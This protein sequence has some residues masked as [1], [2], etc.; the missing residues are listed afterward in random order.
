MHRKGSTSSSHHES[1]S[2]SEAPAA[3][4]GGQSSTPEANKKKTSISTPEEP[5]NKLAARPKRCSPKGCGSK[6]C[7]AKGLTSAGPKKGTH[8]PEK[9]PAGI[10]RSLVSRAHDLFTRSTPSDDEV[11]HQLS[12]RAVIK[13]ASAQIQDIDAFVGRYGGPDYD[14]T[15]RRITNIIYWND[16]RKS[17]ESTSMFMKLGKSAFG[18]SSSQLTGCTVVVVISDKAVWFAHFWESEDF[19]DE[20]V[21]PPVT[22]RRRLPE[23][24]TVPQANQLTWVPHQR[25]LRMLQAR[26]NVKN[27]EFRSVKQGEGLQGKL[28]NFRGRPGTKVFM[29]TPESVWHGQQGQAENPQQV[30]RLAQTLHEMVG[31]APEIQLYGRHKAEAESSIPKA[32]GKALYL[33][34]PG[35]TSRRDPSPKEQVLWFERRQK[36]GYSFEAAQHGGTP[37]PPPPGGGPGG[38]MLPPGPIGPVIPHPGPGFHHPGG[39]VGPVIPHPGPFV[40]HPGLGPLPGPPVIPQP[41]PAPPGHVWMPH[42]HHP[43]GV[44]VPVQPQPQPGPRRS[45]RHGGT[46]G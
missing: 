28:S 8:P 14:G 34:D 17:R 46:G 44:F 40:P 26:G 22:G 19:E 35:S 45:T 37:P 36:H 38:P 18:I 29:L 25:I 30:H 11:P 41:P 13:P 5:D 2:E 39:G 12:K 15:A 23:A 24:Q 16:Q 1:G 9:K 10:K 4:K 7:A 32:Y 21:D 43:G 3:A 33:Y 42:P 27:M 6:G 31:V 20:W